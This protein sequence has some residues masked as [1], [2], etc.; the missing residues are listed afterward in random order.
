MNK[1]LVI[2]VGIVLAVLIS[3]GVIWFLVQNKTSDEDVATT[4]EEKILKIAQED[5]VASDYGIY[6]TSVNILKK[7]DGWYATSITY[8]DTDA[9]TYATYPT[10]LLRDSDGGF[11]IV[12][13][14]SDIADLDVNTDSGIPQE[15]IQTALDAIPNSMQGEVE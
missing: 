11:M 9:S 7:Q 6:A 3:A 13:G 8:L 10:I 2:V 1:R 4:D 14:F 12:S 5:L 15:I